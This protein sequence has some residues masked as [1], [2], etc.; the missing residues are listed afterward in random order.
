VH[1]EH[2]ELVVNNFT[3]AESYEPKGFQDCQ[4]WNMTTTFPPEGLINK[5]PQVCSH[6][7]TQHSDDLVVRT[8]ALGLAG[9]NT[10]FCQ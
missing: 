10:P 3:G 7:Y 2:E 1:Q 5:Q 6:I 9:A 4:L 8:F